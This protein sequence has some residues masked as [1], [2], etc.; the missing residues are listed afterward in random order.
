MARWI[1]LVD[2]TEAE[3]RFKHDFA[4]GPYRVGLMKWEKWLSTSFATMPL[5]SDRCRGMDRCR[6]LLLISTV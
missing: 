2:Q 3:D 5:F 4:C 6:G 1:R